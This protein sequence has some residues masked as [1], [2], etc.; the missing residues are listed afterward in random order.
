MYHE[1]N[2]SATASKCLF[3]FLVSKPMLPFHQTPEKKEV[4]LSATHLLTMRT[5]V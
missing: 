1:L 5:N 3:G 4:L 2:I